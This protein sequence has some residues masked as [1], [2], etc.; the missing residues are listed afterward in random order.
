MKRIKKEK[1]IVRR[2]KEQGM[3]GITQIDGEKTEIK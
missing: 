2:R 3:M 1:K